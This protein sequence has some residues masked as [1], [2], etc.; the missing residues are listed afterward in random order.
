MKKAVIGI[1]DTMDRAQAVVAALHGAGFP[2]H[3]ISLLMP[4][5]KTAQQ[6]THEPS[7]K[8]PEG[9]IAGVSAG[10]ALGGALGLLVGLG[11]LAI[12]G[13]GPLLAAGPIVAAL[14]GAAAGAAVGGVT[15]ALVG[16]GVPEYEA[17]IYEGHVRA[18]QY[19]VAVHTESADERTRAR[20]LLRGFGAL[21]VATMTEAPVPKP[22]ESHPSSRR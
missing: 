15:G 8:A 6:I 2:S 16:M 17:K 3:D 4:N 22:A 18:G 19:L 9:A 12:P 21:D 10:G 13:L 7:T 20:E 1:V 11:A 14:S 5:I